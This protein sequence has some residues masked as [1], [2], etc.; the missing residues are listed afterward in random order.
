MYRLERSRVP[1][2][3]RELY[4][5]A[6]IGECECVGEREAVSVWPNNVPLA[7]DCVTEEVNSNRAAVGGG[8][9]ARAKIRA[10]DAH[11]GDES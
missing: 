4:S 1:R 11:N 7:A 5:A 3:G 2:F 9:R 10:D 6:A 8:L